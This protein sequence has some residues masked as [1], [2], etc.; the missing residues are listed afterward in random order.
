ML[1]QLT[2]R[3]GHNYADSLAHSQA[4]PRAYRRLRR[5]DREVVVGDVEPKV[6]TT[7][8]DNV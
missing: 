1:A 6:E 5:R 4:G 2:A 8:V 7:F 3:K